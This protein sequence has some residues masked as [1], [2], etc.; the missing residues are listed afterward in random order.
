MKK[1]FV[2]LAFLLLA[3]VL[4]A[5]CVQEYPKY[6]LPELPDGYELKPHPGSINS[7]EAYFTGLNE[8]YNLGLTEEEIRDYADELKNGY[9]K[10]A[11]RDE[12]QVHIDDLVEFHAVVG[13]MINLDQKIYEGI[14]YQILAPPSMIG[15]IIWDYENTNPKPESYTTIILT[16]EIHKEYPELA[17][18]LN[19]EELSVSSSQFPLEKY[20]DRHVSQE[21]AA[22]LW[23]SFG[24]AEMMAYPYDT[25]ERHVLSENGKLYCLIKTTV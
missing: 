12:N 6:P 15:F 7:E 8:H 5:G 25:T 2:I 9:L 21:R 23:N 17:R 10:D 13:Y 22:E 3:V 16:E 18:L 4:S 24:Y 11:V 20:N 14:V 1:L 19:G